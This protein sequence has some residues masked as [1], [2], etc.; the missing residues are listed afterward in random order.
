MMSISS[1]RI[2]AQ[3]NTVQI[4]YP[5]ST[6][7]CDGPVLFR[8]QLARDIGCILD[9]DD[10]ISSWSCRSFA[11]TCDGR[12]YRPDFHVRRADCS[13]LV[14][15]AREEAPPDWV[16]K[17]ADEAG[18][19]YQ[20]VKRSDLPPVRLKNAK[21]L[22]R[23][24]R[25]EAA[26]SDRVRLLGALDEC[27]SLT[28]AEALIVFRETKPMAGL[29]AMILHRFITIDLDERLIGPETVVRRRRD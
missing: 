19:A 12:T 29:A 25:Y 11:L 23:Y 14:D 4:Y 7:R 16:R 21:D 8:D 5:L 3:L 18:L 9:V 22:M 28:V 20:V 1:S 2:D 24:A 27:S 17:Q 13:F 15:G 26:L 6:V 10:D